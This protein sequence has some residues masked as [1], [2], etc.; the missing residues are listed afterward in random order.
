MC[1]DLVAGE[2]RRMENGP[3]S[4]GPEIARVLRQLQLAVHRGD[5][6]LDAA[7]FESWPPGA[8]LALEESA[9]RARRRGH[10]FVV[11]R[12]ASVAV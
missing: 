2:T 7:R 12:A 5:V 4:R 6:V 9:R 11:R 1:G 3:V 8:R 10:E